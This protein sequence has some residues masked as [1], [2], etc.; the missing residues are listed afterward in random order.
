MSQKTVRRTARASIAALGSLLIGCSTSNR[1][2]TVEQN[3]STNRV[4]A[5]DPLCDLA[6][7]P[8]LATPLYAQKDIIEASY[9]VSEAVGESDTATVTVKIWGQPGEQTRASQAG[10]A[11]VLKRRLLVKD[12]RWG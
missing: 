4:V 5:L 9:N 10:D 12:S 8:D 3:T 7:L 2:E 6:V 1:T 11:V